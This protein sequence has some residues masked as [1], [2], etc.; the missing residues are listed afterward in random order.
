MV[1]EGDQPALFM[2]DPDEVVS[3]LTAF[4]CDGIEPAGDG[5]PPC[6]RPGLP[7]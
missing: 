7:R 2:A 4:F 5:P 3:L 6:P 1:L